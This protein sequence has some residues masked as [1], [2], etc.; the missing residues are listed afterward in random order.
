MASCQFCGTSL[1]G[2]AP[3]AA[4]ASIWHD[5]NALPTHAYGR[6]KWVPLAYNLVAVYMAVSGLVGAFTSFLT[7]RKGGELA[8]IVGP[9][10]IVFGVIWIALGIGLL[11]KVEFIRGVVNFFCG[12]GLI[13]G[14]INL[15]T[16]IGMLVTGISGVLWV[17][18]ILL[19]I[20]TN[21]AMIYLVGETD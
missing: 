7:M 4:K 19:G 9:I 12:L 15:F 1:A 18:N 2:V 5:D 11:L 20:V 10:G 6:P 21:A 14:V 17:G 13:F 3:Q 8:G 16:S